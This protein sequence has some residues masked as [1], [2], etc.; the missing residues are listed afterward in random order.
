MFSTGITYQV[1]LARITDL[2]DQADE[3]RRAGIVRD[4]A[5]RARSI[6]GRGHRRDA[7]AM[8]RPRRPAR[9]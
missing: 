4:A 1:G 2:R 8:M 9:A 5:A 6:G 3:H 7:R